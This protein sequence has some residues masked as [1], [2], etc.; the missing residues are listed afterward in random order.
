MKRQLPTPVFSYDLTGGDS[1]RSEEDEETKSDRDF[2]DDTDLKKKKKMKIVFDY[3]APSDF[4][5]EE[6]S[7]SPR[8]YSPTY[9]PGD[10]DDP[11]KVNN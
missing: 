3:D 7:T 6:P 1:P 8:D 10:D 4:A 11:N 2:I 5:N 9:L